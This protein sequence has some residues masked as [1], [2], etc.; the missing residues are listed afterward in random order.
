MAGDV[1]N[2]KSTMAHLSFKPQLGSRYAA[3]HQVM[4]LLLSP[5]VLD[6][7]SNRVAVNSS[8]LIKGWSL[9]TTAIPRSPDSKCMDGRTTDCQRRMP[10]L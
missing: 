8:G 3:L 9:T 2:G 10:Q 6:V 1:A 5:D 4:Q 7:C